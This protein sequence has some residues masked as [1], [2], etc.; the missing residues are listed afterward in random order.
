MTYASL[1]ADT[2]HLPLADGTVDLVCTSPP[3]WAQRAYTDGGV[4]WAGQLGSEDTPAEYID[5]LLEATAEWCRV[6][7]PGGSLWVN[8]GDKY[9]T[10]WGSSR[11]QGRRGMD[12]LDGEP[13]ERRGRWGRNSTGVPE[14]SLVGLPWRYAL[15]CVDELGLTLRAEVVWEKPNGLP[16]SVTDR[17][18]RSHEQ[19]FH[20]STQ[21]RYYS[22]MDAVREAHVT[23]GGRLLK[24]R[25]AHHATVTD[26]TGWSEAHPAELHPLGRLPGSVWS[27]PT[28]P[29]DLPDHLTDEDDHYASFPAELPRRI[30]SAWSPERVCTVCGQGRRLVSET[31]TV[32]DKARDQ[33][34]ATE[35]A[36]RGA[37]HAVMS[38][39][40]ARST[41]NG[42][43]TRLV[44]G[45]VCACT[46]FT[47]HPGTGEPSPTA[48]PATG[49]QPTRPADIGANHRR[50]GPWTEWHLDGWDPPPSTPGVVLD[51]LGGTGTT[52]HVA[53]ALGRTGI[54][55][56]G[57]AGYARIAADDTLA[58]RR[59]AKVHDVKAPAWTPPEDD[60]LFGP[61]TLW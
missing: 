14:K 45:E 52:A 39:G 57:S 15:A 5:G 16:E 40:T 32:F 37:S 24:H 23:A 58:R 10:R 20:L 34:H 49:R 36:G 4:A 46:P 1:R 35:I 18:R 26:N 59:W 43:T 27:V 55:V 33:A 29:L 51:P 2:R 21:P 22:A 42:R 28:E 60:M 30:V 38:G 61:R 31:S 9:A 54:S 8:L 44:V 50:V 6:L 19:W 7:K 11:P 13:R 48:D 56:D 3:Y 12:R 47:V 25:T 53:H 17:V 41:L